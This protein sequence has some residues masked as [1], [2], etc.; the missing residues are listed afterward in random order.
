VEKRGQEGNGQ[1]GLD[2]GEPLATTIVWAKH[3]NGKLQFTIGEATADLP[4]GG[5]ARKLTAPPFRAPASPTESFRVAA[6]DDGQIVAAEDISTC[7]KSRR[8]VLRSDLVTCS[9]SGKRILA[10]FTDLCP[11]SGKPTLR[12]EFATCRVCRQEVS[13][14]A[15]HGACCQACRS[16]A[17]VGSDDPRLVWLLGE[18]PSLDRFRRWSLSES[19]TIYVVQASRLLKRYLLV[20]E[21]ETTEVLRFAKRSFLSAVW[22]DLEPA[23]RTDLLGGR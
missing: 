19:A 11:V 18:Y 21:K 23:E 15:L 1:G 20:V 10:Q 16:L 13:R 9:V 6:T 22:L 3:V 2:A 8:R 17:P 5:W 14:I 4:F 7:A 12:E